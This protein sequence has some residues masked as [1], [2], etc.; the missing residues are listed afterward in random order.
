M[1]SI[2]KALK[3]LEH[4]RVR[5]QDGPL[6][7]AR[8][9]L[10]GEPRRAAYPW[11][12]PAV[13]GLLV[14]AAAAFLFLHATSPRATVLQPVSTPVAVAGPVLAP[15]KVA[16]PA[17]SLSGD[18]VIIEEIVDPRRPAVAGN[19]A[20]SAPRSTPP[21]AVATMSA[22]Q[23]E[24]SAPSAVVVVAAPAAAA[25]TA[26]SAGNTALPG[27]GSNPVTL[28]IRAAAEA[29]LL[30]SGIAWQEAPEE[31]LAVIN[32]LPVMEGT[33]IGDARV[34]EI[35]S[36]R[37]IFRRGSERFVILLQTP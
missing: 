17:A 14:V 3:K 6:D 16:G 22:P 20:V 5:R 18:A 12:L 35:H 37:V 19:P 27:S 11:L 23:P 31:R 9:I 7:L 36:D 13:V 8:D 32:D 24:S 10:R 30:V 34:E 4:E 15:D 2:L 25:Q 21:R 29:G 26:P 33:D 1:S 28:P